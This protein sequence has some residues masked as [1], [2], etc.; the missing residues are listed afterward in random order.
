MV[1]EDSLLAYQHFLK[2]VLVPG[3]EEVYPTPSVDLV[4]H[5]HQLLGLEYRYVICATA[6][7]H[8]MHFL[9]YLSSTWLLRDHT[10]NMLG[11]FVDHLSMEQI[12]PTSCELILVYTEQ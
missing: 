6:R 10:L 9:T 3:I 4:W 2:M 7:Q 12:Q 8:A 11:V 1:L 5:T